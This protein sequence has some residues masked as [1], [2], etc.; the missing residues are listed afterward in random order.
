MVYQIYQKMWIVA[1]K[2]IELTQ[3]ASLNLSIY[4]NFVRCLG[5]VVMLIFLN[6]PAVHS[7]FI[8]SLWW[9]ESKRHMQIKK[10]IVY[11]YKA[12]KIV[13]YWPYRMFASLFLKLL[14]NCHLKQIIGFL[15][16]FWPPLQD[17]NCDLQLLWHA[18]CAT[19][20]HKP[21][22]YKAKKRSSHCYIYIL[23]AI[24]SIPSQLKIGHINQWVILI[25]STLSITWNEIVCM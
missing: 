5:S 23:K 6:L 2:L 4:F 25:L 3:F 10:F 18:S 24:Y 8:E 12:S 21:S 19:A 9:S 1:I 11:N 22:K 14:I 20:I 13:H 17:G 16:N 15:N 7:A